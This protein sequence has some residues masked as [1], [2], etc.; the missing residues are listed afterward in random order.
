SDTRLETIHHPKE[1]QPP[2][3]SHAS[4]SACHRCEKNAS[5]RGQ[6]ALHPSKKSVHDKSPAQLPSANARWWQ[7]RR[8]LEP[9]RSANPS[10]WDEAALL[11]EQ[12]NRSHVA[13]R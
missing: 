9:S 13:N 8:E 2:S 5:L 12:H 1:W 11:E 3:V 7:G 6:C 4:P 10:H